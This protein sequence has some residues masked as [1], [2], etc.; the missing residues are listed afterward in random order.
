M[1]DPRKIMAEVMGTEEAANLYVQ[2]IDM[3]QKFGHRTGA[4]PGD[5]VLKHYE[6]MGEKYL[7][8][9]REATR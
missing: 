4:L 1:L 6:A 2:I 7:A 9:I 5:D 3:L 8:A